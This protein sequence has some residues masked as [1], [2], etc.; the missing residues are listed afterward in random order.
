MTIGLKRG[1][2][3]V[4]LHSTDW[5]AAAEKT[6]G[7]LKKILKNDLVD[8]QHIGSTSIK[9]ICAKPIVDIVVGVRRFEDILKHNGE[10]EKNGI[11]YRREE[12]PGE[13]LYICGDL[14]NNIHTHYIHVVIWNEKSWNDYLNMRD[15][16]NS[17]EAVAKEYSALKENL[18]KLYPNDRIA[19]TAQKSGF[20]ESVLRSAE[21]WRKNLK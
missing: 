16:L 8:A 12:R 3:E 7:T 9:T 18:A 6:I 21:E 13:H 5:E 17:N 4:C 11:I 1:K 15:Y 19:Y 14:N 2:V 20:I 10:L